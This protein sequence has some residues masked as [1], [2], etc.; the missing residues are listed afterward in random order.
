LLTLEIDVDV[1][2]PF[3]FPRPGSNRITQEDFPAVIDA[4]HQD[5]VRKLGP[6]VGRHERNVG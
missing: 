5:F 4:V 6:D 3:P 2:D 1:P